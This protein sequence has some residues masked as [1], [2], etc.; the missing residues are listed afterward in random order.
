L[1]V[2]KFHAWRLLQTLQKDE[3]IKLEMLGT[4]KPKKASEFRYLGHA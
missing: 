3:I 1:G 2:S 4:K